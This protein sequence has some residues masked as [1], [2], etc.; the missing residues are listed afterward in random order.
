MILKK[1]KKIFLSILIIIAV[2]FL[3][4]IS[5]ASTY[6]GNRTVLYPK[7]EYSITELIASKF[8]GYQNPLTIKELK[9]KGLIYKDSY[10]VSKTKTNIEWYQPPQES[11]AALNNLKTEFDKLDA[12]HEEKMNKLSLDEYIRIRKEYF[13]APKGALKDA[14]RDLLE[15]ER[16]Q[17]KFI[18]DWE[19]SQ[20]DSL[21]NNK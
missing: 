11:K 3:A 10:I 2:I 16:K 19:K 18:N 8:K 20:S 13:N 6:V 7:E 17:N 21:I 9:E 15:L 5:Y 4:K 14:Y 12:N 1:Y